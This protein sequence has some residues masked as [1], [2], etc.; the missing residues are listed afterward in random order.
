MRWSRELIIGIGIGLIIASSIILLTDIG[1]SN[2][3]VERRARTLGM[4]R[5]DET[6]AGD[7]TFELCLAQAMPITDVATM[8]TEGGVIADR[9]AFLT[10]AATARL[11]EVAAGRYRFKGA[12]APGAAL[13]TLQGGEG[14]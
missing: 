12:L 8:L 13:T 3:E 10:E 5:R 7:A 4:I 6:L 14:K 9:Q 2:A 11:S 1:I